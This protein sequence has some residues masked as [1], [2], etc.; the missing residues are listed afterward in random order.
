DRE[1]SP[2][3]ALAGHDRED[4]RPQ[5]G[6]LAEIARDRFGLPALLGAEPRI[7]PGRVDERDDGLAELLRHVH[8]PERLAIALGVRHPEV[9]RDLLARVA[10][11]LVADHH[12]ALLLEAREPPA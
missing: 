10:A 9:A 6:H 4:R 7:G 8:Q 2:A 5:R 11:L 3:A 12:D 1:R